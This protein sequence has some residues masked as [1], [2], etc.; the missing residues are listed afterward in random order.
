MLRLACLL[1]Y[2]PCLFGVLCNLRLQRVQALGGRARGEPLAQPPALFRCFRQRGIMQRE[3][4]RQ[5]D[6][7]R[8]RRPPLWSGSDCGGG[9]PLDA[10]WRAVPN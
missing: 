2:P 7:R 6:A 3:R 10:E 5:G 8:D 1:Q 4:R 9:E